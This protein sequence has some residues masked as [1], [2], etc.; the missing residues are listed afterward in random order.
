M[1]R[2]LEHGPDEALRPR[3]DKPLG[4]GGPAVKRRA[5]LGC[6][7][8]GTE[9]VAAELCEKWRG[10]FWHWLARSNP[11][12]T[13]ERRDRASAIVNHKAVE[14]PAFGIKSESDAV[15]AE[16]LKAYGHVSGTSPR[17]TG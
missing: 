8:G 2:P 13:V 6:A 17:A 10:S 7:K 16:V 5:V 14:K 9:E 11:W 1:D 3:H 12:G 4:A 15:G